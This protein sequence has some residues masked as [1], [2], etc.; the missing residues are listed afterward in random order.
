MKKLNEIKSEKILTFIAL[1]M[2]AAMIAY[3]AFFVPEMPSVIQHSGNIVT[4]EQTDINKEFENND[5][6]INLNTATEEE[7]AENL[8]GIGPA[9]AKRIINY[10]ETHGGFSRIEEIMNV[11]GIGE[12]I[13]ER[14]KNDITVEK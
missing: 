11:K 7:L 4:N 2:F 5:G 10:R 14:I 1:I 8:N 6:L 3:N 13:F 9:I 12:K